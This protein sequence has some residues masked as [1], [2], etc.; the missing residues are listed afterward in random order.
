MKKDKTY[1]GIYTIQEKELVCESWNTSVGGGLSRS[2][3]EGYVK[4]D[5]TIVWIKSFS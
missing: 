1:W 3:V 5:S 4:N 2:R